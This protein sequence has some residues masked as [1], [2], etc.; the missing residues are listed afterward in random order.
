MLPGLGSLGNLVDLRLGNNAFTGRLPYE[1]GALSE[2]QIL[3]LNGNMNLSPSRIPTHYGSL[4]N[5]AVL[6]LS[7]MPLVEHIPSEL[8]NLINLDY[9]NLTGTHLSGTVPV[10]VCDIVANHNLAQLSVD[11][12]EVECSC[13]AEC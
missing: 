4:A 9:L 2:L 12:E 1:Y 11:C 5:L 3:A 6:Q 8:G 7:S 10:E 13:C